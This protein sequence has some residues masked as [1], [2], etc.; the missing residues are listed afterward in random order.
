MTKNKKL[1]IILESF[2][3]MLLEANIKDP[4]AVFEFLQRFGKVSKEG[5]KQ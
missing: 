5:R 1:H 3:D 4:R 2:M